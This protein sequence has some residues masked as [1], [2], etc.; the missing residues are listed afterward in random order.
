MQRY[1]FL[2]CMAVALVLSS[3]CSQDQPTLPDQSS[4]VGQPTG[5]TIDPETAAAELIARAGWEV[6][7]DSREG[8]PALT[9]SSGVILSFTSEPLAGDVVHHT[10]VIQVGPGSYD[11]I[12]LHRVVREPHPGNP[13]RTRKSIFLQHGDAVGFVKFLFGPASPNTADD[14]AAAIYLAQRDIDVWGIDQNW[15]LAPADLTDQSVMAGWGVQ[16]QVDNLRMGMAIARHARLMTGNG[17]RKMILLGYSSGVMTGYAYLNEE[18]QLPPGQ[19]HAS[20]FM[21]ADLGYKIGPEYEDARLSACADAEFA[22]SEMDAGNYIDYTPQLFQALG[23][24]SQ[25]DPGGASPIIPGLTNFE[26]FFLF[27]GQTYMIAAYAPWWHYFA[28]VFDNGDP[29]GFNYTPLAGAEDFVQTAC[30][31]YPTRFW[32]DLSVILCDEEDVPWDDHLSEITVP[33]LNIAPAGGIGRVADY[34]LTLLGSSDI[35]TLYIQLQA[36]DERELDFGHIDLWTA[37][38]APDLVWQPM[39]D[40]IDDHTPGSHGRGHDRHN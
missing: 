12:A 35:T 34:P 40:W 36:D 27:V 5:V 11:L 2:F 17:Y 33:I 22:Q 21:Q 24:L 37:T 7:T 6:S 20:G 19:R 31:L 1:T 23:Y 15:V 28:P 39:V 14:H 8:G 16:N 26:A 25:T 32:Y 9:G 4:D 3:S 30:E 38:N 18:S 13:M 29:A 10:F